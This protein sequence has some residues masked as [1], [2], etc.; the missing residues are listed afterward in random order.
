M[1]SLR[2]IAWNCHHGSL[3]ARLAE[4]AA[5]APA[6]VFLQEC[7]P[8]ETAHGARRAPLGKVEQPN[9]A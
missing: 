3:S 8:V 6:I 9:S 1:S 2:L 5:F 4:L 7:R